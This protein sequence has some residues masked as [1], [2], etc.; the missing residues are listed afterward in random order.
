[1]KSQELF[2]RSS[3]TKK[4]G[5][6]TVRLTVRVDHPPLTVSFWIFLCVFYLRL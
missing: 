2:Q 3:L 1:M 6:F 4:N 5:L